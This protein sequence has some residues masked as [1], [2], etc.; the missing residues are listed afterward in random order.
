MFC[1]R[2]RHFSEL[3]CTPSG[4]V[5]P[6]DVG[7]YECTA[8]RKRFATAHGLEVQMSFVCAI[9]WFFFTKY[10]R[11]AGFDAAFQTFLTIA[12]CQPSTSPWWFH[13]SICFAVMVDIVRVVSKEMARALFL[14]RA[15]CCHDFIKHPFQ[16]TCDHLATN[17]TIVSK[18][19]IWM[20]R[21][22]KE[23]IVDL[24]IP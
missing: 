23:S 11:L 3:S 8:C 10:S 9:F 7:T 2:C 15:P 21:K 6:D 18:I 12:Q 24:F 1:L 19:A 13:V 4:P 5:N 17:C 22:D 20:N 14:A 16:A